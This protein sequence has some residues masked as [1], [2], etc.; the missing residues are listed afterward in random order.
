MELR[1]PDPILPASC[2]TGSRGARRV[3]LAAGVPEWSKGTRCKGTGL[4]KL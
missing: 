2:P 1:L 4:N 3:L